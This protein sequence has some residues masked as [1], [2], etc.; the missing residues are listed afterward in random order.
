MQPIDGIDLFLF[1][2]SEKINI[3]IQVF[4]W[5]VSVLRQI[6]SLQ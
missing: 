4:L 6:L 2:W 5:C 1:D 3:E